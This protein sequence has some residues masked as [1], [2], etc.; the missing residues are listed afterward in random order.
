MHILAY[1]YHWDR[2]T[3]WE[4]SCRERRMWVELILAQK[5]MEADSIKK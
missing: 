4:L 5:K 3:V 2:N 1:C